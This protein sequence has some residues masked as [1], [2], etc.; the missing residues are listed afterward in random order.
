MDEN[1][2]F[3]EHNDDNNQSAE[4]ETEN[5]NVNNSDL[6]NDSEND[7][8]DSDEQ[9]FTQRLMCMKKEKIDDEYKDQETGTTSPDLFIMSDEVNLLLNFI[10]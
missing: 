8:S 9:T 4:T 2:T 1:N 7:K 5:E 6:P 10:T 3:Q